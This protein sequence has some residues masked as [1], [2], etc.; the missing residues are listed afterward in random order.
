MKVVVL[1]GSPRRG[2]NTDMLADAF[3]SGASEEN[4]VVVFEVADMD[5]SPCIGCEACSGSGGHACIHSDDMSRIYGALSEADVLVLA[6][7]VYFYGASSQLKKVVDRLHTPMR[8]G[9]RIRHAALLSVGAASIPDLFDPIVMQYRM[10]LRFFGIEDLGTVLVGGVRGKGDI[11]GN[12]ALDEAYALGR[13]VGGCGSHPRSLADHRHYG[14]CH[15]DP[16][17][18]RGPVEKVHQ[19]RIIEHP[20]R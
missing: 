19:G 9:F 16:S 6:T 17:R 15:G 8:D 14:G 13:S 20:R 2:G 18:S 7:P 10:A 4:D 3:V 12:P 11:A 5:I 1:N